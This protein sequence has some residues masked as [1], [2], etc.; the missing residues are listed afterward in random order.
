MTDIL[1]GNKGLSEN[2]IGLVNTSFQPTVDA[3]QAS[4]HLSLFGVNRLP[5]LFSRRVSR[6][7]AKNLKHWSKGFTLV[8]EKAKDLGLP[9]SVVV[10]SSNLSEVFGRAAEY[11]DDATPCPTSSLQMEAELL[12][13]CAR[14]S[15][16]PEQE[17][18]ARLLAAEMEVSGRAS[19][20]LVLT[21]KDMDQE[22]AMLFQAVAPFVFGGFLF[23]PTVLPSVAQVDHE[24]RERLH[25]AGLLENPRRAASLK[26]F[27]EVGPRQYGSIGDYFVFNPS[28]K[29]VETFH[30]PADPLTRVGEM[31][32]TMIRVPPSM[33]VVGEFAAYVSSKGLR[34]QFRDD[35]GY[36]DVVVS[37][38]G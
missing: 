11:V 18:W 17:L 30:V 6:R 8:C 34:L 4:I 7:A 33:D 15:S 24:Q 19:K 16:S 2:T 23:D 28:W 22:E 31:L 32:H 37:A 1:S 5:P 12:E 3:R 27:R 38:S 14:A 25:E 13:G 21:L 10:E 35:R 29:P 9:V 26:G 36:H 20:R